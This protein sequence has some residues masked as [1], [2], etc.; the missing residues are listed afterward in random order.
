MLRP[1]RRRSLGD[2]HVPD[3]MPT[4]D[5]RRR[6]LHRRD[7]LATR[8]Q[9]AARR[10]GPDRRQRRGRRPRGRPPAAEDQCRSP[11]DHHH[12][13]QAD[14]QD[15]DR[16]GPEGATRS[17]ANAHLTPPSREAPACAGTQLARGHLRSALRPRLEPHRSPRSPRAPSTTRRDDRLH[18]R[19]TGARARASRR[20]NRT[21][22]RPT[23]L[24]IHL[25]QSMRL[26]SPALSP[27]G[28]DGLPPGTAAAI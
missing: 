13:E 17:A 5:R 10:T 12:S 14:R 16:R 6:E 2:L 1:Q 24:A 9:R 8:R 20:C 19:P 28:A 22:A 3:L 15:T 18:S 7:V 23:P 25:P 21:P 11:A 26:E 4:D 27:G